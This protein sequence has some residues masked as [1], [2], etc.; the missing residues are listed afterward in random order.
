MLFIVDLVLHT[1]AYPCIIRNC[2]YTAQHK[3]K[4]KI[5][6]VLARASIT[7]LDIVPFKA[8]MKMMY[9]YGTGVSKLFTLVKSELE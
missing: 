1:F 3:K 8:Y 7:L 9:R 2:Y 4:L 5:F 6:S